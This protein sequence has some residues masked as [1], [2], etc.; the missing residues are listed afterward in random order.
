MSRNCYLS[1]KT[2]V[3][4]PQYFNVNLNISFLFSFEN[5]ARFDKKKHLYQEVSKVL[6]LFAL[7]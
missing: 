6:D 5:Q 7:V 4:I 3:Y 1:V 2:I